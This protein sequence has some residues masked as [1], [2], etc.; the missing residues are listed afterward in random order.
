MVG[1]TP[2]AR[3]LSNLRMDPSGTEEQLRNAPRVA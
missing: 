3:R 1:R 2:A